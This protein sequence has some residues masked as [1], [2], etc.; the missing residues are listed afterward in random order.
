MF[1]WEGDY[2]YFPSLLQADASLM[3]E[4]PAPSLVGPL[5]Q[6]PLVVNQTQID[7][8]KF[9][10][11][12]FQYEAAR[13][14]GRTP[15]IPGVGNLFDVL[16]T[17]DWLNATSPNA[18]STNLLAQAIKLIKLPENHDRAFLLCSCMLQSPRVQSGKEVQ[19]KALPK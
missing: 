8:C 2:S 4:A 13:S 14:E 11:D 1:T 15:A 7:V 19:L 9:T 17:W 18:S 6:P 12:A 16:P 3:V 10:S 5:M